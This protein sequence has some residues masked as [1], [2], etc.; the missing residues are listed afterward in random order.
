LSGRKFEPLPV[1]NN[2]K[3]LSLPEL[4]LKRKNILNHFFKTFR[5]DYL[6]ALSVRKKWQ[7][8]NEQNLLGKQVLLNDPNVPLY[9]WR[10]GVITHCI[11]SKD[12]LVRQVDVKTAQNTV[13]RSVNT[14]SLFE[15]AFDETPPSTENDEI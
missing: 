10:T 5:R 3:D 9:A 6:L 1:Q 2:S 4:W 8:V 13:R 11:K 12:G 7:S 15:T 14:L